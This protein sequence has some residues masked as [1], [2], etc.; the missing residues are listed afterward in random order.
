MDHIVI[1][2]RVLLDASFDATWA[3]LQILARDGML[4]RASEEAYGTGITGLV[5]AAGPAAGLTRLAGIC[6]QDL[7]ATGDGARIMLQWQAI[8]ADG[9]LF[10]ALDT[11]LTLVPAAG[12]VIALTMAAAYRPQPGPAGAGLDQ[13][14]VH[15]CATAALDSFLGQVASALVHPAGTARPSRGTTGSSGSAALQARQAP[16]APLT[17]PAGPCSP[18]STAAPAS[19][20]GLAA[21]RG[22]GYRILDPLVLVIIAVSVV[23]AGLLT[24]LTTAVW[25]RHARRLTPVPPVMPPPGDA[26][27][28]R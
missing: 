27:P 18:A 3:R 13:A 1:G 5:Q 26:G 15:R 24:G 25:R 19:L 16:T 6:L 7:A 11:A 10:T 17:T 2:A 12:Q 23:L 28:P 8:A 14:I 9:T 4:L 22:I 21:G 20:T